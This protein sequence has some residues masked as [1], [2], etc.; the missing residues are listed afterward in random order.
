MKHPGPWKAERRCISEPTGGIVWSD[1]VTRELMFRDDEVKR[2]ILA[3]PEL[4]EMVREYAERDENNRGITESD[5]PRWGC[6]PSKPS[7]L[8]LKARTLIGRIE[9]ENPNE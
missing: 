1:S 7:G 9:K 8:E 6:I 4:L 2:L 5:D 3:A